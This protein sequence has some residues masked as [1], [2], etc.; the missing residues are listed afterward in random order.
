[1]WINKSGGRVDTKPEGTGE[2]EVCPEC[3]LEKISE[4]EWRDIAK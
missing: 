3:D 4:L 1:M 2:G